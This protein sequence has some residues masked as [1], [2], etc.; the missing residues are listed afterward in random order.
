MSVLTWTLDT[1]PALNPVGDEAPAPSIGR[2]LAEDPETRELIMVAGDLV[3]T[4]D[5]DAIR[6]DIDKRLR[7]FRGEWFL[8]ESEGVP[9]FE[10]VL[11]KSPDLSAIQSVFRREL[12]AVDGVDKVNSLLSLDFNRATRKLSVTW[13]VLSDLGV[14]NGTT[15]VQR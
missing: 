5:L 10:S 15:K 6:Q 12:L 3:L 9:Y 1:P 8:D 2:D 11:V 4:R 14:I 13:S 7:T